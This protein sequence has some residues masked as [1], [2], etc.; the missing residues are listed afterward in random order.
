MKIYY[1]VSLLILPFIS[2]AQS[3][4]EAYTQNIDGTEL[5]L[6]MVPVPGGEFIMGNNDGEQ[7]ESPEV[8]VKVS[9]FWMSTYE[10]T[11]DLFEPFMFKEF[12]I[13]KS[14]G[15]HV[16][17]DVDAVTRPTKP[18]VDMSFNMGKTRKPAI[19]MTHY[20]AI[21]YCKWLYVR[22][23]VFYRLPTEAEW[24][25]A[26]KEGYKDIDLSNLEDY[27]WFDDNSD[28]EYQ[29]VGQKIPNKFG[30]Y[31][32]LGNI[33]EWVYD[34]YDP[35]F[36][37]KHVDEIAVDPVNEANKLYPNSVRGGN[38]MSFDDE[39]S[40]TTREYSEP[41]WKDLDP[42]I[43]KSDWWLT[44]APF[45]GI[46]LVRPL[47]PPSKEEIDRYFEKEPFKDF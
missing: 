1:W 14:I 10:V 6:D 31:D 29:E 33:S 27:A 9:P 12:E 20:A 40:P 4:F 11:W 5:S 28:G 23:G 39:L 15:N 7:D 13:I 3:D 16:P 25:F 46:R 41:A 43:P 38:F 18:Y 19:A 45:V 17:A 35:E 37:K 2:L 30:I 36:Y 8:R 24:E 42:Q 44:S 34:E 47:N 22:T 21:Q 26:A 32:M